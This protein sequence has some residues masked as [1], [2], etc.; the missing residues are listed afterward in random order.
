MIKMRN[1]NNSENGNRNNV[2]NQKGLA[3][4]RAHI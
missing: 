4:T 1:K 2:K 3:I